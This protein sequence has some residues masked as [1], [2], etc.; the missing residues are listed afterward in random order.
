M[1]QNIVFL[2]TL[3]LNSVQQC[4]IFAALGFAGMRLDRCHP[5]KGTVLGNGDVC[6]FDVC[7]A[8]IEEKGR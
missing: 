6:E 8:T 3:S 2:L 1:P 4:L 5:R 7:I